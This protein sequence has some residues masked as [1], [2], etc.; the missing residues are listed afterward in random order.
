MTNKINSLQTQ[1]VC[2]ESIIMYG[3]RHAQF[4]QC[5]LS[6]LISCCIC[7]GGVWGRGGGM[8]TLCAVM[9]AP[10]HLGALFEAPL[11]CVAPLRVEL[12][13]PKLELIA[14]SPLKVVHQSPV[15]EPPHIVPILYSLL[16]L[17]RW[18]RGRPTHF[19]QGAC[20]TAHWWCAFHTARVCEE[21]E[22]QG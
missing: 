21:Q 6:R 3:T 9:Q 2:I 19:H 7:V 1:H 14:I 15:H 20:H 4:V 22:H 10:A 17:H 11:A 5:V 8:D 12:I 16:N 18:G 13:Q